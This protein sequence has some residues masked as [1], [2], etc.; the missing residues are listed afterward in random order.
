MRDLLE[1]E[2][3]CAR[4]HSERGGGAC[5]AR[6]I[7]GDNWDNPIEPGSFLPAESLALAQPSGM[8]RPGSLRI[9]WRLGFLFLEALVISAPTEVKLSDFGK[10]RLLLQHSRAVY[11]SGKVRQAKGAST[12][13][14]CWTLAWG[15]RL[16]LHSLVC[17]QQGCGRAL[18]P[19]APTPAYLHHPSITIKYSQFIFCGFSLVHSST[20]G[21][22]AFN[23]GFQ[24]FNWF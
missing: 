5:L 12:P 24:T 19:S 3:P 1:V 14:V 4:E 22:T 2:L 15:L 23:P 17:A 21:T 16:L 13:P 6:S 18:C 11:G 7:A 9:A 20:M 10:S 8:A